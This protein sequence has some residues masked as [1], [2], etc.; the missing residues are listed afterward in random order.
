MHML[1]GVT[2]NNGAFRCN[3]KP[4]ASRLTASSSRVWTGR[5]K[6]F[7][8]QLTKL[9]C[10]CRRSVGSRLSP[11]V[12][13]Q[14]RCAGGLAAHTADTSRCCDLGGLGS[15]RPKRGAVTHT[16]G[17]RSK[18]A[19]PCTL[20]VDRQLEGLAV[21]EALSRASRITARHLA[22]W[23]RHVRKTP[24]PNEADQLDSSIG[25]TN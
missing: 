24:T 13:L 9:I 11:A 22:N 23:C 6:I 5:R 1:F 2:I 17:A 14:D 3:R 21:V 20:Q 4:S 25:A 12:G 19:P 16:P 15:G 10:R 18:E 7:V 8:D